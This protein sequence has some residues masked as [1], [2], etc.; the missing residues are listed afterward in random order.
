MRMA[1]KLDAAW[2]ITVC[3]TCQRACCWQ[4]IFFCD[5]FQSAGTKEITIARA[6]KLKLE[7]PDYWRSDAG[8]ADR[9]KSGAQDA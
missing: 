6:R 5:D 2:T 1:K 7:H 3:D 9:M 4:G 8:I